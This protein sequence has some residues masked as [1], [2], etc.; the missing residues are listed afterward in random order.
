MAIETMGFHYNLGKFHHVLLVRTMNFRKNSLICLK[1][2][3]F[4]NICTYFA[5]KWWGGIL[6]KVMFHHRVMWIQLN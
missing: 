4:R 3:Y 2:G 6:E 5:K 1:F